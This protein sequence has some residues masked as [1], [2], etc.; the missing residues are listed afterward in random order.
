MVA[1][2]NMA[3]LGKIGS[4][5]NM[6]G[7]LGEH[8]VIA[9]FINYMAQVFLDTT[10]QYGDLLTKTIKGNYPGKIRRKLL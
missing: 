3:I 1:D 9:K 4:V 2:D 7:A 10:L 8:R 6:N 5:V